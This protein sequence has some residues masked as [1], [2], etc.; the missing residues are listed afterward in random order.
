MMPLFVQFPNNSASTVQGSW[1]TKCSHSPTFHSNLMRFFFNFF[2]LLKIRFSSD[3]NMTLTDFETTFRL[4]FAE[5]GSSSSWSY[6]S[7]IYNYLC[8]Q[9]LSALT[10]WVRTT[11]RRGELNTTLCDK[12]FQWLVT[13]RWFS[14]GSPVSS[15]NKTDR[16]DLTEILLKV[17]I[18][19]INHHR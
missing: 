16:H 11:L 1:M 12:V 15:T 4:T 18:N 7:W 9:F 14:P 3:G 2:Y 17:S 8:N 19:T 13:G 5:K 6:G 10:L